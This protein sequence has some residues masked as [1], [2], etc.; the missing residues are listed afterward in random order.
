MPNSTTE[1]VVVQIKIV[2]RFIGVYRC[3][4]LNSQE[5]VTALVSKAKHFLYIKACSHSI[6]YLAGKRLPIKTAPF[7]FPKGLVD[8]TF[9]CAYSSML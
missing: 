5:S 4:N 8:I 3:P 7:F 2:P 9:P 6:E 1:K